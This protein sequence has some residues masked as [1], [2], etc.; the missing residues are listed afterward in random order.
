MHNY[1]FMSEPTDYFY[2]GTKQTYYRGEPDPEAPQ[3]LRWGSLQ[4][5]QTAKN[6][7]LLPQSAPS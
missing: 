3:A 2:Y 7:W 1:S 6:R 5:L 4:Q